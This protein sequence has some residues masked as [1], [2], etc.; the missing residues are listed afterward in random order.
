[1]KY[2][3][4]FIVMLLVL[5]LFFSPTERQEIDRHM[6]PEVVAIRA[7]KEDTKPAPGYGELRSQ[8]GLLERWGEREAP[9]GGT[10]WR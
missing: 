8:D 7:D 4:Q 6:V 5:G 1:M 2:G 9:Q 10:K 3:H